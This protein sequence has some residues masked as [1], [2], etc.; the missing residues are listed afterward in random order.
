MLDIRDISEKDK[1]FTFMEGLKLWARL[2]LQCQQVTDLGSAMAA[3]KR[4]ADFNPENKRD[5]RQ[6]MKESVWLRNAVEA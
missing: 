3:A 4:L 1:F 5:R 2:E 6:H